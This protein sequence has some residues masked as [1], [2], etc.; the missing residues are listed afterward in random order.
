MS[1]TAS[2]ST[3]RTDSPVG[4]VCNLPLGAAGWKPAPQA[5][6]LPLG[7]AGWKPAPQASNLPL[8]A[9]GWKPAPRHWLGRAAR[10]ASSWT[11]LAFAHR[12]DLLPASSLARRPIV[13][14]FCTLLLVGLCAILACWSGTSGADSAGFDLHAEN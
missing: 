11:R 10:G 7:A 1:S 13:L 5:S 4:Q 14:V 9:A 2:P 8:G 12:A 3:K 6:N